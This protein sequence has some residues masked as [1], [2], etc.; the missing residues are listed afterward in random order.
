MTAVDPITLE[1]L[2][3]RLWMINDEQGRIG[4]QLSGSPVVYEA[5]DFNTALQTPQG[6]S[7]FV[8]I[9]TTRLSLCLDAATKTIL[10][11]FGASLGFEEGDAFITNDPWAG[12]A[13]MNDILMVAPIFWQDRLVAWTGLAMHEVDVGGPNPGSFTVGARDV[14]GEGPIIPPVKL[15]ERWRFRPDIE[16]WATRNSR[17]PE[18]NGLN[19]RARWAAINR[20]RQRLHEVIAEY[21]VETFLAVQERLLTLTRNAFQRRLR[22]LP[23]GT[24]TEEA[25]LDHDG[26]ENRL[27]R[28]CLRLTKIDDRLIFDFRGTSP[29][30]PGPINCT[31]VGLE[32]GVLSAIL[33]ALC[34]DMPWSPAAIRGALEIISEPGTLN[35]ALHPAGVSMATVAATFAT[36]H[37]AA[38]AIGKLLACSDLRE[39]AQANWTPAWQGATLSGQRA[40]GT[41]FTGVLLDQAGGGGATAW[42]DGLDTGGVPGSPSQG[43]ANVESYERLF[44]IL[45]VYRKQA[46]DTG[47]PGRQRGGVGTETL[48]VPHKA[49]GPI[50]LTVLTHGA[51]QP[52]ARGLYGGYPG[53]IQVRLALRETNLAQALAASQIPTRL[54]EVAQYRLEPLAA[55]QRTLLHP[56][57]ALLVVC[58]GG[59]GYGDPLLRDPALVAQDVRHGLVSRH[60]AETL[61]GVCLSETGAV[62]VAATE[63]QRARLRAQRLAE[64]WGGR[65]SAPGDGATGAEPARLIGDALRAHWTE[66]GWRFRC[67]RCGADYGVVDHPKRALRCREL[68]ITALSSWNRFGLVDEIVV[69][70]FYCPACAHLCSVEVRQRTDPP[71]FDTVLAAPTAARRG[72]P[73]VPLLAG[74]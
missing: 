66:Q 55:K 7:L 65:E 50:D 46:P 69:R 70:E 57:D 14:F 5:K 28:I 17:T 21:G 29:Q 71:L 40:D 53:S 4:A 39:E 1:V 41:R 20:T 2:R 38:A 32:S 11:R 73:Q 19:L 67:Q 24:W 45:Y 35:N 30:A 26:T 44:P 64:G 58:A 59:G 37:V 33:P 25:F 13:H 52:E 62:D 72:E 27:Y 43:I 18:L 48:L 61:Y 10:E 42:A 51:S 60:V 36:Q 68:P 6:D 22:A 47:G 3:H 56:H 23:D 16:A 34:Y 74:A 15:V 9:Y 31:R 49:R 54:E 63:A 8:G 12:A